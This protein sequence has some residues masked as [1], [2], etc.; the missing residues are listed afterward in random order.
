MAGCV[1]GSPSRQVRVTS[2]RDEA[3]MT[4]TIL[5]A[6]RL[7]TGGVDTHKDVHVA[8]VI[9]GVGR[10]L[11]VESFP[12]TG[13][14]YRDLLE[15]MSSF[16]PVDRVGVEG[17]GSWGAGLS[18]F[19]AA[20]DVR[21]VEVCRPDRQARRFN[22]KSDPVDAEAAALAALSGRAAVVPKSGVGPVEAIRMLVGCR[23]SA[24]K[25][26]LACWNQLLSVIDSAPDEVRD[27]FRDLTERAL[28]TKALRSRPG[29]DFGDP[30][31]AAGFTIR[32][33]ARR[34]SY[35]DDQ[36]G[37]LDEHL[38][39]A[40]GEAAPG[41]VSVFGVGTHTAAVLLICA[42]DNPE[43]LGSSAA[44][45][46]LCGASPVEASSG[47]TVRHRLNRGG[48]RQANSALWRIAMTRLSHD[49]RTKAY[50]ARRTGEGL[51][52]REVIRCLKRAIAREVYPIIV[53]DLNHH[54]AANIAA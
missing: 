27:R 18:R 22:G 14:G 54:Q 41:L 45:A 37:E 53:A 28:I 13:V 20:A 34:W 43:R 12:T 31:V 17:T 52:K 24:V 1:F 26:K 29:N 4:V 6:E 44:F 38:E 50:M 11:G 25:A 2:D 46:A 7:V 40:V 39:R 33:L 47:K 49:P 16:G 15:W 5:G 48:N 42:G 23:D 30:V 8:A 36:I 19:L 21:V 10:L 35:L 3:E 51:S 9:D 32:E